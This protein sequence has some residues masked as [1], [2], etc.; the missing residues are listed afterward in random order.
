MKKLIAL[1]V[2]FALVGFGYGCNKGGET[3]ETT[4]EKETTVEEEMTEGETETE[5]EEETTE[6]MGDEE[7]EEE[8]EEEE[9]E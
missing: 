3:E 5:V 9:A 4:P 2:C 8:G 1:L 6:E 7:M